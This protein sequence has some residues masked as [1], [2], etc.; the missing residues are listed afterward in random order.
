[1]WRRA[2]MQARNAL[3]DQ[4][5]CLGADMGGPSAANGRS[6]GGASVPMH[7]VEDGGA[8]ALQLALADAADGLQL[9]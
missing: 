9:I 7:Q 1:M 3:A 6:P 8:V 5:G 4:Y 2:L